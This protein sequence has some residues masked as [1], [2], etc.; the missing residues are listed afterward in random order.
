MADEDLFFT[1]EDLLLEDV[2]S[3]EPIPEPVV[4]E[5]EI[6]EPEIP[7]PVVTEPVVAEP[8]IPEPEIPEP[9]IPE[10]V[11][12]RVVKNNKKSG[13][14]KKKDEELEQNQLIQANIQTG[15]SLQTVIEDPTEHDSLCISIRNN[16]PTITVLNNVM[17]EIADEAAYLK[18]WRKQNFNLTEDMFS[19]VSDK[20]VMALKKIIETLE[21]KEKLLNTKN[22]AKIDF[23]SDSF[24][25][26]FEYFLKSVKSTFKKV[27][28]PDQFNDIFFSQLAKELDGFEDKAERLY[29]GKKLKQHQ[30]E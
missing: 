5:P 13:S 8:E 16:D 7:E 26:I 24:I 14:S 22:N 18:A 17:A 20:R 27:N 25:R 28:I 4:A 3:S 1:D 2:V 9:E 12:K 19:E 10:P 29:Y 30:Q 15:G 6:P 21:R 11:V 23:R